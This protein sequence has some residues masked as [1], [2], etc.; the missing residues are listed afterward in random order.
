MRSLYLDTETFPIRKDHP[1]PELVCVSLAYREPDTE[2]AC[3]VIVSEVVGNGD[4]D[5]EE[6]VRGCFELGHRLVFLNASYDLMVLALAFPHLEPMIWAKLEAEEID[7][8]MIRDKMLHLSTYGSINGIQMPDGSKK[9]VLYNMGAMC[10][11]YLGI[12]IS[13]EKNDPDAPRQ[14]YYLVDDL[15]AS[16]YPRAYY[17]YAALDA[18]RTLHLDEAITDQLITEN[19]P[20]SC[21]T[22]PFHTAASFGLAWM[23]E[24]GMMT[25]AERY[26][27]MRAELDEALSD[28]ALALLI[29]NEIVRP[30]APEQP[31]KNQLKKACAALRAHGIDPETV[32]DW[33]EHKAMLTEAGVLY[34][35]PVKQS[36]DTEKLKELVV[37]TCNEIGKKVKL[38]AKGGV[39][40]DKEVIAELAPHDPVL[41]QYG[42]RQELQKLV[43]TYL[44]QMEW[45]GELADRVHFPFS[46]LVETGRSS[47]KGSDHYPSANGQN[48]DP[49]VRP[50]FKAREGHLI[51]SVDYATLELG[52]VA[53]TTLDIFGESQH[54]VRINGGY[55]LHAFLGSRLAFFLNPQFRAE[56]EEL[57]T[58]STE[59]A[60]HVFLEKKFEDPTFFKFW[61]KF[62]KPVGLGYP[63]GLGPV[64]F[65]GMAKK[66][67]GVDIVAEAAK[68][69]EANPDLFQVT[70]S[71]EFHA[72]KL[73]QLEKGEEFQWT[74]LLR[75]VALASM[76]REIWFE[77]YPEMRKYFEFVTKSLRDPQNPVLGY[78]DDGQEIP[79]YCYTTPLGMH[80]AGAKFTDAANGCA[81]QSPAAEGA[82]LAV[83]RL[84]RACRDEAQKSILY[85]CV[86]VDFIHDEVLIEIPHDDL[87]QARVAEVERIMQEAMREILPDVKVGTEPAASERWFKQAEPVYDDENNLMP[88]QPD[89]EYVERDG[90]LYLPREAA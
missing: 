32:E 77:T 57:G 38:T 73:G 18:E 30:S 11:R 50:V 58:T 27:E 49:R 39:C 83:F 31:R 14:N 81:M 84:V 28:D 21:S 54:A 20:S 19:G 72:R 24:A 79:G 29:E 67:Y 82:K 86:P 74:P 36:V 3:D 13:D 15:P 44:P 61:R 56:M 33:T 46:A 75:G 25:D 76:L 53:Q 64:K 85:G 23:T 71:L 51:V 48:Q 7:D 78:H 60:Y 42:K 17:E 12:D 47:S 40:C 4:E 68:L 69:H 62:A 35:A 22:S 59:D 5:L 90:R 10:E 6:V 45:E 80:R 66:D 1:F 34:K 65:I 70:R 9:Q 52:C 16:R 8:V 41:E 88:W 87:F 37:D 55:D 43:T 2:S 26:E 63:G 89:V